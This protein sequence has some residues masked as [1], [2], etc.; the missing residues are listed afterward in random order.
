MD[1]ESPVMEVLIMDAK[2][3]DTVNVSNGDGDYTDDP[4]A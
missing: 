3:V 4:W 2:N 1:Y